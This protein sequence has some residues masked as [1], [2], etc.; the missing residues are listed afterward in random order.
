MGIAPYT[1]YA[2]Q[3]AILRVEGLKQNQSDELRGFK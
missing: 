1:Y 2:I 3:A